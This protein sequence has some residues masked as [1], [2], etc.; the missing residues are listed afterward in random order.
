[1]MNS[2]SCKKTGQQRRE[3][4][5]PFRQCLVMAS[6]VGSV[7]RQRQQ[8][9]PPWPRD[10]GMSTKPSCCWHRVPSM[11]VL[12]G[13]LTFSVVHSNF[14]VALKSL[15]VVV[16]PRTSSASSAAAASTASRCSAELP[17][18]RSAPS[19]LLSRRSTASC[20]GVLGLL[21]GCAGLL[22]GHAAL[23]KS[24]MACGGEAAALRA[25]RRC[26][27][28]CWGAARQYAAPGRTAIDNMLA[29]V[30]AAPSCGYKGHKR[31]TDACKY[32]AGS[33]R[34]SN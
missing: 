5:Q 21:R 34:A 24:G 11:L 7:H 12:R 31:D 17:S 9:R 3:G 19:M 6:P 2:V 28:L 33:L 30:A 8:C 18:P 27:G 16:A 13:L 4:W 1:M 29:G 26:C 20:S 14:Q 32:A 25:G 15:P 22:P 10:T 23:K